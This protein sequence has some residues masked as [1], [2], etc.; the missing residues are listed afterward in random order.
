MNNK[1]NIGVDI[2][3]I[4]YEGTGVSRFTRGLVGAILSSKSQHAY[5]FFFSGLNLHPEPGLI[6][7][8]HDAGHQ[9][10]RW[11]IPPR[12]LG[13]LWNAR[14]SRLIKYLIP[15]TFDVWLS[16][17]WTQPPPSI[18]RNRI[19]IVHDLVFK[20]FT[21]TVDPLILNTQRQRLLRVM[22]E[23][24]VV[25]TDS[26]STKS[27]VHQN[28]PEFAG[29]I[30]TIYPGVAQLPVSDISLPSPLISGEYFL[31][32][33]KL[34][35]RKN[36]IR[37]MDAFDEWQKIDVARHMHNLVIVG[38]RGWGD[39]PHH[40]NSHIR[41]LDQVSD[42]S[43]AQLYRHALALVMP[44]LYEGFGYPLIE[45]MS[46]EC[47]VIASST[48][49]LGE[50]IA[51]G[52]GIAIDPAQ[53]SSIVDAMNKIFTDAAFRNQLITQGT[54]RAA[55]FT[56]SSYIEKLHAILSTFSGCDDVS[57]KVL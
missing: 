52:S 4:M 51:D 30:E 34:E 26:I 27:D 2:S 57:Q 24:S 29:A 17:D 46:C 21:E 14:P 50:L 6:K 16:S 7:A 48:S 36:L 18:A 45:A 19:T 23:C 11:Y 43:L 25:I 35:P 38:P 10:I 8:I 47:P 20:L 33:G 37:L 39:V 15:G 22:T 1:R 32:V 13:W 40:Q 49:S 54:K 3:Q 42:A 53:T 28:Y 5:T 9:Y 12:A 31:A 44:S 55:Q 41:I 56:W